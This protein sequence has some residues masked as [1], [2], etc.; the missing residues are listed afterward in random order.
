[1]SEKLLIV[2]SPTKART[3]KKMLGDG[4]KIMASMGHVRD[5]PEGSFGVDIENHFTPLYTDTPRSKKV[6]S[7]LKAAAR[8]ADEVYLAPDPDRE[9]EAI[10][11][12]LSEV[13]RPAYQGDFHRVTFHEITR[14]AI[15]KALSH[16]SSIDMTLVDAQQARRVLDRIVGYQVSP[17]LWSRIARGISAGRVQSVALRLVVERERAILGFKPE[18]YWVFKAIFATDKGNFEA[19]L[20]K[21]DAKDFR[22]TNEKA[23]SALINSIT[24]G[25]F[26]VDKVTSAD[27]KRNAQPPFTTSTLQQAANNILHYSAAGTMRYAQQ[28]YEGVDLGDGSSV[29]LI[30]YMRTDSVNIA[31]EAQ[32]AAIEFITGT[33]GA[34][35]APAKPNRYKSKGIVQEAHEAIRPTDVR[36]TPESL[37]NVL[38]AAQLKLYTLIWRRF[39]ASQMTPAILRQ[40]AVDV[41]VEGKDGH[42]YC[43]RANASVTKFA[44]HTIV[45]ADPEKEEGNGNLELFSQLKSGEGVVAEKL[46]KEQKFTEPPPRFTDASLVKELEENGIGRPSTYA[47]ILQTLQSRKYVLREQGKLVPSELGCKVSDFLVA[48]LP[49]LFDVGFTS[50]MESELDEIEEGTLS[51]TKMLED[52]YSKFL[53]WL[54][55]AKNEG[56]PENTKAESLLSLLEKVEFAAPEKIGRRTFDD[57]KFLDSVRKKYEKDKVITAKQYEALLA[58]AVK[59]RGQIA[60]LEEIAATQNFAEELNSVAGKVE[61]AAKRQEENTVS[62]EDKDKFTEIFRNF[63]PV[64]W[65][66]ARKIGARVYDDK[67]F[68]DSLKEQVESGK[69]LSERQIAALAKLAAKYQEQLIDAARV[70]ELLAIP[71]PTAPSPTVAKEVTELLNVLSGITNWSEP[72]KKGRRT[73]DDKAFYQ[74][75]AEQVKNG[76]QLS[77][78]QLAALRKLAGKYSSAANAEQ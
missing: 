14:S 36:R 39:V 71:A 27:R 62:S 31:A 58:M 78:K 41:I 2:E 51:W 34:E 26:V 52:F 65:A 16:S 75:L 30:T 17:L 60:N 3:I 43:F 56:A 40:V 19:R 4:Y 24:G 18:E 46:D 11:W 21:I 29:G 1:M 44:G 54:N 49:E 55:G 23:A 33:Y 72:V 69:V 37:A 70:N 22:I 12:H 13:L 68:F 38:D 25:A 50:R 73:Y 35:Y 59:Y 8:K 5:L 45:Y 32:S 61:Q 74:S 77:D 20:F 9:G 53:P 66:E 47:S 64:E 15:E 42:E 67:K 7:E 76:R 48:A 63:R 57:R 28:L 10:A 6:V